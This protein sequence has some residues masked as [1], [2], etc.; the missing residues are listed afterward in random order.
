MS[1]KPITKDG[2]SQVSSSRSE[3]LEFLLDRTEFVHYRNYQPIVVKS[4]LEANNYTLSE[5]EISE[6]LS[7]LNFDRK[8]AD[9]NKYVAKEAIKTVSDTRLRKNFIRIEQGK[10]SLDKTKFYESEINEILKICGKIIAEKHI[11]ICYNGNLEN[12]TLWRIIPGRPQDGNY[13]YLDEFIES[14]TIGIGWNDLGDLTQFNDKNETGDYIDSKHPEASNSKKPINV[15]RH[16]MKPK[17]FV[18]CTK[19]MQ[20]IIDFGIIVSDYYYDHQKS[21]ESKKNYAHRRNVVWL[22]Q[23]ELDEKDLPDGLLAGGIPTCSK[24]VMNKKRLLEILLGEQEDIFPSGNFYVITQN[25]DSEYDDIEGKQYAYDS[26]KAHY[27]NFL[28]ETNFVVQSKIDGKYYFV[29]YGKVS[30]LQKTEHTKPNGRKITKIIAPYS[31]YQKFNEKKQR[32]EEISKKINNIAFPNT[33]FNPQ[34]PAMLEIPREL[35]MEIIGKNFTKYENIDYKLSENDYIIELLKENKNVILYGP[36]GTGK[37]FTADEISKSFHSVN[38]NP[39]FNFTDKGFFMINGPWKNWKHSLDNNP[40]LWGTRG[41]DSSD[42]GIYD[43]LKAGDIVIFSN[44]ISEPGPFSK[45]LIFGYG[46][47]INKFLGDVP[48]WPDEKEQNQIIYKYRFSI[49][50]KFIT[51]DENQTL[52]WWDSLPYTKGFNKIAKS[53]NIEKL[54]NLIQSK[55]ISS[56]VKYVEK[57][58][59]HPSYSYEDFIE[60]IRPV[61][62]TQPETIPYDNNSNQSADGVKYEMSKGIFVKLCERARND[63]KN[64]YLLII[65]EINRGNISKIF[66]EL[67]TLIENDKREERQISLAYSQREFT[68]PKNLLILGTMNTADKSLVQ[69]DTALRRRFSFVE[70]MPNPDKI[71]KSLNGLDLKKLM[72]SINE[73]IR[74]KGLREKQI[75]HSYFMKI[76]SEEKLKSV[77]QYEIIPLL[78]DYFY[79]NYEDLEEILGDI[80]DKDEM[81]INSKKLN[82][83]NLADIF[84]LNGNNNPQ[85]T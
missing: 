69:I 71:T 19:S 10:W 29:G 50:P 78:Q 8:S 7:I 73:K 2:K 21:T 45:K 82:K 66:G 68:V 75:G 53:E 30:E 41:S 77:F 5:D 35:F 56:S 13:P 14:Q 27:K 24:V 54:K 36:P 80:V 58:T 55:W 28:P 15:F 4:L 49:D 38:P 23:E 52:D 70:L 18:I 43:S 33:G 44:Q 3:L 32:T 83:E 62:K 76:D 47:V 51:I 34:P 79:E 11:E 85:G 26:D 9:T 42:L 1:D 31:Y 57:I 59:F 17:D 22:N 64:N 40:I 6:K 63:P 74:K 46:T 84:G 72:I 65:D 67:I 12:A 81:V 25:P 20:G 37:T 60:G 16:D 61:L 48:F 39:M